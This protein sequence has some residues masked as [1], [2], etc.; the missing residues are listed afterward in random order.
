[1]IAANSKHLIYWLSLIAKLWNNVLQI[2][3][4]VP[5]DFDT[6]VPSS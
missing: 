1:M 5:T 4:E 3:L 2:V 6:S